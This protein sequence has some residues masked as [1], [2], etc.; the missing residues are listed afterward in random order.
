MAPN[1]ITLP[2]PKL[3]TS[4]MQFLAN[5]AFRCC[6]HVYSHV[7]SAA[8]ILIHRWTRLSSN[9]AGFPALYA[10]ATS[11]PC[12][13]MPT[14]QYCAKIRTSVGCVSRFH[15][16]VS[17]CLRRYWLETW[18]ISCCFSCCYGPV[19]QVKY[20]DVAI[21]GCWCVRAVLQVNDGNNIY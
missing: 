20:P 10:V 17:D 9:F 5:L 2:P 8:W 4:R 11:D 21:L 19:S 13:S 12:K 16:D 14:S 18:E 6:R 7:L 1:I 3:S 15:K